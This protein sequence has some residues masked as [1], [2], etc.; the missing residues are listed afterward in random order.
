[1]YSKQ[2]AFLSR[3][4][5]S[6]RL[7]KQLIHEHAADLEDLKNASKYGKR[8]LFVKKVSVKLYQNEAFAYLVLDPVRKGKE[9]QE[10]L[11]ESS[12]RM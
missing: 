10:L 5:C 8:G 11:L 6:R 1:M 12:D 4:P 7:Y 2:I 3:L 9:I